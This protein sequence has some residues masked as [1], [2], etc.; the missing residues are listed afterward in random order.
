MR[1]P[2]VS[3]DFASKSRRRQNG[4]A[5]DRSSQNP[6]LHE[7]PDWQGRLVPLQTPRSG[8]PEVV[9]PQEAPEATL[10]LQSQGWPTA[11]ITQFRGEQVTAPPP[12][13]LPILFTP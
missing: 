4:Q 13:D 3:G 8:T 10:G 12:V 7:K 11:G 6:R 1:P 2:R 5:P 9:A